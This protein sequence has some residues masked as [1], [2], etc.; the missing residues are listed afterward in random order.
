M[1]A[2][3]PEWEVKMDESVLDHGGEKVPG[4]DVL[5]AHLMFPAGSEGVKSFLP[6]EDSWHRPEDAG[7]T[8]KP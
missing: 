5:T 3:W 8:W 2:C 7:V 4:A 6:G 1:A